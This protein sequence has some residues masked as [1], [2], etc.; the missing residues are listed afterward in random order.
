MLLIGKNK[1]ELIIPLK[2]LNRVKIDRTEIDRGAKIRVK[3][4]KVVAFNLL[5]CDE[6]CSVQIMR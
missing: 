5:E 2:I 3:K 6:T 1:I 4:A